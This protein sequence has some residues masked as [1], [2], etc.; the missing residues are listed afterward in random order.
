MGR[1]N[2]DSNKVK[3]AAKAGVAYMA[4]KKLTKGAFAVAAVA[5]VGKVLKGDRTKV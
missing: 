4:L 3:G 5:A 2:K 1:K